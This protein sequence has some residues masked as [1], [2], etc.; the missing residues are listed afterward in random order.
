MTKESLTSRLLTDDD[1]GGLESLYASNTKHMGVHYPQYFESHFDD[2]LRNEYLNPNFKTKMMFGTFVDGRLALCM[3]ISLWSAFPY[4]TFLRFGSLAGFFA[5]R[6]LQEA[7]R[8]LLTACLEQTET[9][10]YY[11]FY[12]ITSAKH[13]DSLAQMGG[14]WEPIKS[15]YLITVESVIQAHEKPAYPYLWSLMGSK[16]WPIPLIVRSGTL[17]NEF[18]RFDSSVVSSQASKIWN[19]TGKNEPS[20]SR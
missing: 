9:Q 15:R 1:L 11:R 10:G 17:L 7:F 6:E 13:Q 14:T 8:N 18:R 16:T 19:A 5:G 20:K 3:G 12:I 2:L 4:F